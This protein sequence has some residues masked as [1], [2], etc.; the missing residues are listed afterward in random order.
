[1]TD[2][3]RSITFVTLGPAGSNHDFVLRRYLAAHCLQDRAAV[4]FVDDFHEGAR[5]L[6]DDRAHFML[7]CAV[8]PSTAEIT[9]GYRQSVFVVDAFV[10]RSQPMALVRAVG[11]GAGALP[12]RVG[13]QPATRDYA[14]LSHWP[15]GVPEPTVAA[16]GQALLRGTYAA[17]IAFTTLVEAHPARFEVVEAIGSVCDAWVVYGTQPV[18]DDRAVVWADS[19]V[20][21]LYRSDG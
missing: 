8:H 1:M 12:Q 5:R 19:P 4:V 15:E 11:P 3:V 6:M 9:G 2:S 20:A 16:V 17:G 18:D 21:R 13:F 10:S 14:D 7:Q